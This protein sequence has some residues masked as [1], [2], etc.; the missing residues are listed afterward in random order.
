MRLGDDG[1]LVDGKTGRAINGLGASRFD[2]AIAA[3]RGDLDPK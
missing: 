1:R 2:V 3:L